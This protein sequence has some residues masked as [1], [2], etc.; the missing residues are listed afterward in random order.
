MECVFDRN[1]L[2]SAHINF[3]FGAGVNGKALPQLKDFVVTKKALTEIGCDNTDGIEAAIDNINSEADRESIKSIFIK[4]FSAF[5]NSALDDPFFSTDDSIKNIKSLLRQTYSLVNDSQNRNPSMKQ[6]NVYT[7]NYDTIIEKILMELGYL[8]NEISASNTATKAGLLNVIGYD[9]KTKKYIPTFVISKLHGDIDS[10]II[11]GKL[12]YMEMLNENYFE[13]AFN[14]KEKLSLPNSILIV[15]GYSG[16]DNHI[17][18][19][20]Q[21][22]INAGLVIYWYKYSEDDIVPFAESSQIRIREQDDQD[23]K[24]D[25]TKNCYEDMEQTWDVR[26]EK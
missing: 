10:P 6:I 26:L 13:I 12:K 17:N 7:L 24:Q 20:L 9:Y 21:D 1:T 5:Q 25:T 15:I 18:K 23:D 16:G 22:C 19:I 8:Y 4:E 2:S 14:M 3:L 11:P